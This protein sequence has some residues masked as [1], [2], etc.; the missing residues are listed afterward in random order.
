MLPAGEPPL[1]PT[2][3]TFPLGNYVRFHQTSGTRGRPL[4]VY[5]TAA[6]WDWWIE[7]WQYVHDAAGVT[8]DDRAMLAF[9]FG[10]FIGFWSA[11][12]SLTARV[13]RWSPPAVA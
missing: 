4:P 3:L 9:S 11:F 2:N 10:P 13:A 1:V 5:D 12:D 8:A 7:C 6:D